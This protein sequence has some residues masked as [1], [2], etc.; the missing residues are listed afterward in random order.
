MMQLMQCS[1]GDNWV[2]IWFVS[3][4]TVEFVHFSCF[5]SHFDYFVVDHYWM[6]KLMM[7]LMMNLMMVGIRGQSAPIE[8]QRTCIH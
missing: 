2:K 4:D 5:F 1:I 8:P 6:M 3:V 7:K